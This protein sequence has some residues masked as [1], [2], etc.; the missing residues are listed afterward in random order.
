MNTIGS[1]NIYIK[2]NILENKVNDLDVKLDKILSLLE[3][4]SEDCKKMSSHIDFIDGVYEN[5]KAPM[6]Y[7]CDT[8]NNRFIDNR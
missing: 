3:K 2:L 1:Q 5:V 8:M 6:N 7:I 4:N